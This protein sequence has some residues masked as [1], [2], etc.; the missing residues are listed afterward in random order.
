[1]GARDFDG[2]TEGTGDTG[3]SCLT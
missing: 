2:S 3:R 1:V